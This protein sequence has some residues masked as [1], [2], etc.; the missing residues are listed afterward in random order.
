MAALLL[1]F[2]LAPAL[3][4]QAATSS[5]RFLFIIDTSAA[6]KPIEMP[7]RE[8]V[9]DLIYS[10][11]RGRMTNGDTYGLWFVSEQ[12][13]TSFH[14]E[15]W[16]QKYTV[17]LGA[18]AVAALKEHGL[19][20]KARLD[21]ALAD[22]LRIIKNVGDLT[23]IL[24]SNGETPIAGTP[25]DEDINAR[26]RELAP[27]MKRAKATLNTAMVA[28]DGEFVAWAVNSPDFLIEVPIVLPKP[29]PLKVDLV[30]AK[31]NAPVTTL[32]NTIT[33][34]AIAPAVPKRRVAAAPII[35]T[36]ESVAQERRSY[37]SSTPNVTELAPAVT[38]TNLPAPALVSTTKSAAVSPTNAVKTVAVP[39]T[40][41]LPAA[42]TSSPVVIAAVAKAEPTNVAAAIIPAPEPASSTSDV[43]KTSTLNHA[44]LWLITGASVALAGMFGVML[45]WR[46]RRAEPSL[47]SQSLVCERLHVS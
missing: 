23:V 26:F 13:D 22:A 5:N 45:L 9:F 32:S 41:V 43:P 1:S 11:A 10:G 29:K 39:P 21:V 20:G 25:S 34:A 15:S 8:T 19:K 31:T 18:K 28:Q 33:A 35:I 3:F 38:E 24:V 46:G 30:V 42:N 14:M 36:K 6:M 17:E 40:M 16:K 2:G 44:W 12:N 37:T 7:L 47:I 27:E 4:A